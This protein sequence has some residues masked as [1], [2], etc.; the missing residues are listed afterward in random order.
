MEQKQS[1]RHILMTCPLLSPNVRIKDQSYDTTVYT[2]LHV[3]T[4]MY[5]VG[6]SCGLMSYSMDRSKM[7]V[8]RTHSVREN[9]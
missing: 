2:L 6:M 5:S 9:V 4:C 3:P 7:N 8:Q 1:L